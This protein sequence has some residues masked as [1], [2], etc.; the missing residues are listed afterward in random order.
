[1]KSNANQL[2]L[3]G[4]DGIRAIAC[5]AVI[6]HHFAQRLSM[7]DQEAGIREAQAFFLLG[8]SGVSIFFVLSG[9]LLAFPF[10]RNYLEEKE[11]PRLGTYL[12]RRAARI[13]PGYYLVFLVCMALVLSLD[14]PTEHFAW[15]SAAGLT[16]TAG[17]HYVTFFPSEIDGP[18]WSISFEVFCYALM[19]LF[20]AGMFALLKKRSFPASFAYWIGA[21]LIALLLNEL[22]HR[23]LTPGDENRGWEYG[24]IGGAKYWM[25]NY[26]PI[27]FFC[28]FTIGIL[29]AGIAARMRRPSARIDRLKRLGLFDAAGAVGL[30]LAFLMLWSHR[31]AAEFSASWQ[32]QPYFYPYFAAL[33]AIPLAVG[34]HSLFLQK[35][36][37]NRFF[38]YTAKVSF[39]LYLW[40]YLLVMMVAMYGAKDYLY[41]GVASLGR[42]ALISAGILAASYLIATLSF[43]FIEK[44][45][46]DW[47]HGR[48]SRSKRA[49]AQAGMP[50]QG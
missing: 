45:V 25:P 35:L 4:A 23:Y 47:A 1:M 27:G 30:V 19:P 38:R 44:P 33:I 37:D 5:L 11:F 14:I 6:S 49:S 43:Y 12:F 46:L 42:W 41:M 40:H 15:R 9:F 36:L 34:S 2:H 7:G 18:F 8:N 20:M 29:A 48:R 21:W 3:G 32:H 13:V 31:H 28:H 39:G 50:N 22:V 24:N 26:N 17:F 10:W 16:F